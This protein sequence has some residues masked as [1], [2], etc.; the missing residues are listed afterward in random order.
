MTLQLIEAFQNIVT[1][2]M[3]QTKG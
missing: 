2:A 3:K 1:Y